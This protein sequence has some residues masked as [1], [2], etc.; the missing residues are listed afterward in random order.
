MPFCKKVGTK[1]KV[2]TLTHKEDS[3]DKCYFFARRGMKPTIER[4]VL[5]SSGS[6][7]FRNDMIALK[8]IAI[9]GGGSGGGGYSEHSMS[10]SGS[11]GGS[12]GKVE[13]IYSA[14]EVEN[15][16]GQTMEYTIGKGGRGTSYG[17]GGVNGESTIFGTITAEGGKR[18]L[19]GVGKS[20]GAGGGG[21]GGT[22]TIG[23]S[24]GNYHDAYGGKGFEVN[25]FVYG[26][27]SAGSLSSTSNADDGCIYILIKYLEPA[28]IYY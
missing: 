8:V 15:L 18:G 23:N 25:G 24:G 20:G 27:G 2:Y 3:T 1:T 21:S 10:W 13:K 12:G 28:N 5:T 19:M 7:T 26:S 6:F 16:K 22:V 17:S 11:G 14:L 4:T 9:G